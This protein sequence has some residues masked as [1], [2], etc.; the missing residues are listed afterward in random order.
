MTEVRGEL[1][2]SVRP[3]QRSKINP[4]YYRPT[5]VD[6][7]LGDPSKARMELGWM[8]QITAQQMCKEMVDADYMAARRHALLRDHQ[9]EFPMSRED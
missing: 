4:R 8:P 2:S 7:L 6:T 5:E 9:L 3:G 1:A